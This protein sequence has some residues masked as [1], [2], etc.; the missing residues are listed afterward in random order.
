VNGPVLSGFKSF[1]LN[2]VVCALAKDTP[3][4]K[5]RTAIAIPFFMIHPPC[6]IFL[7]KL[8]IFYAEHRVP[9]ALNCSFPQILTGNL[10]AIFIP[11]LLQRENFFLLDMK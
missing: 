6:L 10:L 11:K 8:L 3:T 9:K 1:P 5:N 7:P 4:N 2:V